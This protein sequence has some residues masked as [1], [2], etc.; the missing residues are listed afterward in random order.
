[1]RIMIEA[2]GS[3]VSSATMKNIQKAGFTCIGTD[4]NSE[5][6]G[7]YLCD[8]FYTV[9]YASDPDSRK[10]LADLVRE[11]KIDLVVPTLD[12][13]MLAWAQMVPELKKNGTSVS[14]SSPETIEICEDKWL[15]YLRFAEN[16]IP[17]PKT[18][19]ENIYPLV[20][21]RNGRGGQ[22]ISIND[23]N[24]CMDGMISQEL[25]SGIEY[26]TD[27][28][29]DLDGEPVYIVP[30]RRL[31]VREGKSTEG[32]VERNDRIEEG[33]RSICK[34]FRFAGPVNIQCFVDENG[35]VKFTEINPRLGGG[36]TLGM[37]A[38]ENWFPLIVDI[39]VHG[40]KV[41]ARCPI[42]YGLKMSR[43]YNE[44]FYK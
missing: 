33:I 9:P 13:G 32:I 2:A 4:S 19:L 12:E 42:Q 34:V 10:F 16:G 20:K 14:I 11:K 38:T 25:L 30:R 18:S 21:P 3:L 35:D 27:V 43:Y 36:T 7:K 6:F 17:T 40:K 26:T 23:K 44:V 39:F 28:L 41:E 37:A 22:D 8:E 31:T 24:V 5:S 15:T 1:M 29:C